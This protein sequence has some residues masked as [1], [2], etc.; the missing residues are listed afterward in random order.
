VTTTGRAVPYP[1]LPL[2]V[3]LVGVVV[4][5]GVVADRLVRWGAARCHGIDR[6]A[7]SLVPVPVGVWLLTAS[8]QVYDG[9]FDVYHEGEVL[10]ATRRIA[11]GAFPWRDVIFIHGLLGDVVPGLLAR[12]LFGDSRWAVMAVGGVLLFPLFWLGQWFLCLYLF[13]HNWLL[14]AASQALALL[15]TLPFVHTRMLLLPYLLLALAALLRRATWPRAAAVAALAVTQFVVAP[16][17]S[18]FSL[19]ALLVVVLFDV[20]HRRP[21]IGLVRA[22]DRTLRTAAVAAALVGA[23]VGYLEANGA[24]GAFV[25]YYR[26]FVDGH[27]LSGGI[28][29]VSTGGEF[30][31]WM[32]APVALVVATWWYVAARVGSRRWLTVSDWVVLAA[33]LGVLAY[34]SKFLSR[35]DVGH[36]GQVAATATVPLL[37]AGSQLVDRLEAPLRRRWAWALPVSASVLVAA[38]VLAPV[39]PRQLVQGLPGRWTDT[40]W[41]ESGIDRLGYRDVAMTVGPVRVEDPQVIGD[42]DVVLDAYLGDEGRVFDFTNSPGLFGYLLDHRNATRYFHVSMAKPAAVQRDLVAELERESPELVVFASTSFGLPAWDHVPNA[43]RHY[44]VADHILDHYVPAL[45]VQGYTFLRRADVAE[46]PVEDLAPRL[47]AP[48]VTDDLLFRTQDCDWGYEP[49]FFDVEPTRGSAAVDVPFRSRGPGVTARGWAADAATHSPV[50]ELLAVVDDRVVG[51]LVPG[52]ERPDVATLLGNPA[53]V[54]FGFADT[55]SRPGGV[56]T[57]VAAE[58]VRVYGLTAGG[59]AGELDRFDDRRPSGARALIDGDTRIPVDPEAVVG[60]L[61]LL[62]GLDGSYVLDL[63]DDASHYDWLEVTMVGPL[64]EDRFTVEDPAGGS[65]HAIAFGTLPD[66]DHRSVEVMVGACPQWKSYDPAE[67]LVLRSRKGVTVEKVRL[68]R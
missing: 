14:L 31:F 36:L 13:R 4:G 28:P 61:D 11:E 17:A 9:G 35:A 1:W 42:L 47:S 15:G 10:A 63:P 41:S 53:A 33:V 49:H 58:E 30:D 19:A 12:A 46:V 56:G 20:A 8:L 24:V 64:V 3:A 38:V 37:Y 57:G 32:V 26:T 50:V 29:I 62:E 59:V 25:H 52:G 51:R 2:P 66:I 44:L 45:A 67:P 54:G 27:E 39:S 60:G 18:Y 21:G 65:G 48:P 7:V 23:F 43:V 40:A 68:V 6:W 16:E 5:V 22:F 55:F 34:Y